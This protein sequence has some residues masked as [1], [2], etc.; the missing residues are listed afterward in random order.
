MS[1]GTAEAQCQIARHQGDLILFGLIYLALLLGS[2]SLA[3][4]WAGKDNRVIIALIAVAALTSFSGHLALS[5]E[6]ARSV[7]VVIDACVFVGA[8]ALAIY[9]TQWWPIWFAGLQSAA[10]LTRT[11]ALLGPTSQTWLFDTI[12][13]FWV[14]PILAVVLLG[15]GKEK[16]Q[17]ASKELLP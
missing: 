11:A 16:Q 1:A 13:A 7:T 2:L 3:W 4:L 10:V 15:V 5:P 9:S 12:A 8:V 17:C 14:L 6:I